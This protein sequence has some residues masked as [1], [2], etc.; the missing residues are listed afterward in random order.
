MRT[1]QKTKT[2]RYSVYVFYLITVSVVLLLFTGCQ[3]ER[4][5]TEKVVPEAAVQEPVPEQNPA[6]DTVI[7][8]AQAVPQSLPGFQPEELH[9][10]S[11]A[12]ARVATNTPEVLSVYR[13]LIPRLQ[14]FGLALNMEQPQA[15]YMQVVA[16]FKYRLLCS[17]TGDGSSEIKYLLAL[18]YENPE[19]EIEI[20]KLQK[21]LTDDEVSELILADY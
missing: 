18:V 15:A 20:M 3:T 7:P 2:D 14:E 1:L 10:I 8:A 13:W 4:A 11:G 17:Y 12:Y 21:E 5:G 19:G 9:Q 6:S 16:G